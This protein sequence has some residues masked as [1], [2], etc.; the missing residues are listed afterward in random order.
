MGDNVLSPLL[1]LSAHILGHHL[2]IILHQRNALESYFKEKF[3]YR[4][5]FDSQKSFK[6]LNFVNSLFLPMQLMLMCGT[7]CRHFN[8]KR[9]TGLNGHLSIRDFTLASCQMGSNVYQQPII[10]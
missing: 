7:I 6:L 9:P 3:R 5:H 1:R 8:N 2:I 10:E 4:G